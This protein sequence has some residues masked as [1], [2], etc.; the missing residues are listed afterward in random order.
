MGSYWAGI[1]LHVYSWALL[2]TARSTAWPYRVQYPYRQYEAITND[3]VAAAADSL[4][5][6]EGR[7]A[8]SGG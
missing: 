4:R 8:R 2:E 7:G 6:P 1:V 3:M 5:A